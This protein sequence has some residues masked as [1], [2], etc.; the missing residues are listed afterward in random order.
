M[1][2]DY[3]PE[4]FQNDICFLKL[5][6]P[7]ADNSENVAKIDIGATP[8][9]LEDSICSVAGWGRTEVGFS[10]FTLRGFFTAKVPH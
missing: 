10:C 9:R 5:E 3:E 4:S 7:L 8:K 2:P 1:H 6:R